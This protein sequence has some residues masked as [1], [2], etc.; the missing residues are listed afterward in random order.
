MAIRAL[1]AFDSTD[2]TSNFNDRF[3]DIFRVGIFAGGSVVTTTSYQV[4]VQPFVAVS[5]DG[6]VVRDDANAQLLTVPANKPNGVYICLFAQYRSFGPAQL[7]WKVVDSSCI[8]TEAGS[9]CFIIFALVTTS[10]VG[11][12]GITNYG[13]HRLDPIN[14]EPLHVFQLSTDLP[15]AATG[16]IVGETAFVVQ[17]R[18]FYYWTGTQWAPVDFNT[19]YFQLITN[20]NKWALEASLRAGQGTGVV[21]G[22]PTYELHRKQPSGIARDEFAAIDIVSASDLDE[23]LAGTGWALGALSDYNTEVACRTEKVAAPADSGATTHGST[24]AGTASAPPA[25]AAGTSPVEPV[26]I[27]LQDPA[28]IN[29]TSPVPVPPFPTPGATP[30]PPRLRVGGF[31]AIINGHF[32]KTHPTYINMSAAAA[33]QYLVVLEFFREPVTNIPVS[34]QTF[35]SRAETSHGF[36]DQKSMDLWINQ[37]NDAQVELSYSFAPIEIVDTNTNVRTRWQITL[38]PV[39]TTD[40]N[41]IPV[42]VDPAF[43]Q[44]S[45]DIIAPNNLYHYLTKEPLPVWGSGSKFYRTVNGYFD[46]NGTSPKAFRNE[47]IFFHENL[48]RGELDSSFDGVS[49]A[50]PLFWLNW[51]NN[52][53]TPD[54]DVER[55]QFMPDGTAG[56]IP[57]YPRT[58]QNVQQIEVDNRIQAHC[59]EIVANSAQRPS[60]FT[61]FAGMTFRGADPFAPQS[62][63]AY[64]QNSIIWARDRGWSA[65]PGQG[66]QSGA[67]GDLSTGRENIREMPTVQMDGFIFKLPFRQDPAIQEAGNREVVVIPL[68]TPPGSESSPAR[69]RRD[70]VMLTMRRTLFVNRGDMFY[71]TGIPWTYTEPF[72]YKPNNE[73]YVEFARRRITTSTLKYVFRVEVVNTEWQLNDVTDPTLGGNEVP[74]GSDGPGSVYDEFSAFYTYS[75]DTIITDGPGI[76]RARA[77]ISRE[78]EFGP[79]SDS[80]GSGTDAYIGEFNGR[81]NSV[82]YYRSTEFMQYVQ[83]IPGADNISLFA[84]PDLGNYGLDDPGLWIGVETDVLR[85]P[86][87]VTGSDIVGSVRRDHRMVVD[88][89]ARPFRVVY[90]IPMALVHRKNTN[91]WNLRTQDA[92]H[93]RNGTMYGWVPGQDL[94]ANTFQIRPDGLGIT[95]PNDTSTYTGATYVATQDILDL[96]HLVGLE[97]VE[98]STILDR[99]LDL[100]ARGKLATSFGYDINGQGTKDRTVLGTDILKSEVL[101]CAVTSDELAQIGGIDGFRFLF[102]DADELFVRP[103]HWRWQDLIYA[104]AGGNCQFTYE[105]PIGFNTILNSEFPINVTATTT[106][107]E[108]PYKT[109]TSNSRLRIM[110]NFLQGRHVERR[111][112][113]FSSLQIPV[114]RG[115]VLWL[116]DMTDTVAMNPPISR[117]IVAFDLRDPAFSYITKI[118]KDPNTIGLVLSG[119]DYPGLIETTDNYPGQSGGAASPSGGIIMPP[120]FNLR[121]AMFDR[122]QPSNQSASRTLED[123]TLP[124]VLRN[125]NLNDQSAHLAVPWGVQDLPGFGYHEWLDFLTYPFTNSTTQF[126]NCGVPEVVNWGTRLA[127]AKIEE[128]FTVY[129]SQTNLDPAIGRGLQYVPTRLWMGFDTVVQNSLTTAS[130]IYPDVEQVVIRSKYKS[131]TDS[132]PA[133]SGNGFAIPYLISG[134]GAVVSGVTNGHVSIERMVRRGLFDREDAD[135]SFLDPTVSGAVSPDPNSIFPIEVSD[136]T[137]EV[138]IESYYNDTVNS[139]LIVF[140]NT[141]SPVQSDNQEIGTFPTSP[142]F[143]APVRLPQN[144]GYGPFFGGFVDGDGGIVSQFSLNPNLMLSTLGDFFELLN[145]G[146]APP[147][148]HPNSSIDLGKSRV[149]DTFGHPVNGIFVETPE[150]TSYYAVTIAFKYCKMREG[151]RVWKSSKNVHGMFQWRTDYIINNQPS[152]NQ[153]RVPGLDITQAGSGAQRISNS[154]VDIRNS[155]PALPIWE[156]RITAGGGAP[157]PGGGTGATWSQDP[158]DPIKVYLDGQLSTRAGVGATRISEQW[159]V[160]LNDPALSVNLTD[161]TVAD[162]PYYAHVPYGPV[163]GF[164]AGAMFP[165]DYYGVPKAA[166]T[167]R[168]ERHDFGL[169]VLSPS[170][171]GPPEDLDQPAFP[172]WMCY[173][174]AAVADDGVIL[175][176]YVYKMNADGTR[177]FTQAYWDPGFSGTNFV[178]FNLRYT[179]HIY[180][181]GDGIPSAG[182]TNPVWATAATDAVTVHAVLSTPA[183]GWVGKKISIRAADFDDAANNSNLND[184]TYT[185]GSVTVVSSTTVFTING[186][187]TPSTD[188]NYSWSI[189]DFSDGLV[190]A[191]SPNAQQDGCV[192]AIHYLAMRPLGEGCVPCDSTHSET[193]I[194]NYSYSPYQGITTSADDLIRKLQGHVVEASDVYTTS[195][196]AG[197]GWLDRDQSDL[198]DSKQIAAFEA[199]WAPK[200][201]FDTSASY[202]NIVHY[203]P[204]PGRTAFGISEISSG[205]VFTYMPWQVREGVFGGSV[206]QKSF[207]PE[208]QLIA[209]RRRSHLGE[210]AKFNLQTLSHMGLGTLS[211]W[212]GFMRN[213][214][215]RGKQEGIPI[216]MNGVSAREVRHL[217]ELFE[218]DQLIGFPALPKGVSGMVFDHDVLAMLLKGG[219]VPTSLVTSNS[220]NDLTT[221]AQTIGNLPGMTTTDTLSMV[222]NIPVTEILPLI[223]NEGAFAI[224]RVTPQNSVIVGADPDS[225]PPAVQNQVVLARLS[226][227]TSSAGSPPHARRRIL[228]QGT[229]GAVTIDERSNTTFMM[230]NAQGIAYASRMLRMR[231][232][233]YNLRQ[234][235]LVHGYGMPSQDP[236][237]VNYQ[238]GD[239]GFGGAPSEIL[240]NLMAK[241]FPGDRGFYFRESFTSEATKRDGVC[242]ILYP[243]ANVFVGPDAD[244]WYRVGQSKGPSTLGQG[245]PTFG[246]SYGSSETDV[247]LPI[248]AYEPRHLWNYLGM[249]LQNPAGDLLMQVTS[250]Y[251]STPHFTPVGGIYDGF[252]PFGRP[253]IRNGLA[254]N[255]TRVPFQPNVDGPDGLAELWSSSAVCTS[256]SDVPPQAID[257]MD[258]TPVDL[259]ECASDLDVSTVAEECVPPD[260][261]SDLGPTV[262]SVHLVTHNTTIACTPPCIACSQAPTACANPNSLDLLLTFSAPVLSSTVFTPGNIVVTGP[263]E[264]TTAEVS[265][266]LSVVAA[267]LVRFTPT[268]G[269]HSGCAGC[270]DRGSVS[271]TGTYQVAIQNVEDNPCLVPMPAPQTFTF[272]VQDVCFDSPGPEIASAQLVLEGTNTP[273]G[274]CDTCGSGGDNNLDL[275]VIFDRAVD[276][277]TI[278]NLVVT[279]PVE[280]GGGTVAGTVTL[281]ASAV[282]RFSPT[283][284]CFPA[285]PGHATPN[286]TFNIN[287]AGIKDLAC[288]VASTSTSQVQLIDPCFGQVPVL[289][290]IHSPSLDFGPSPQWLIGG[291]FSGLQGLTPFTSPP[292][293]Y[294]QN[295]KVALQFDQAIIPGTLAITVT[296]DNGI[297]VIQPGTPTAGQNPGIQAGTTNIFSWVPSSAPLSAAPCGGG[298]GSACFVM[299][300]GNPSQRTV[301]YTV[302]ISGAQSVECGTV[303]TTQTFS[304]TITGAQG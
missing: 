26:T 39:K 223:G 153:R 104:N 156:S 73:V 211:A 23:A 2:L 242:N 250:G 100:L 284:H 239:V 272:L 67:G 51:D 159:V 191:D 226:T 97:S 300:T 227:D 281:G 203:L 96:R 20:F 10:N 93:N 253:L 128:Y 8:N 22:E 4:S 190:P 220:L 273:C 290:D 187:I 256:S 142:P 178:P 261:A 214:A 66:G 143:G 7:E 166:S 233:L 177:G 108:S 197:A 70:L 98:L 189:W 74:L 224:V 145:T 175:R 16:L 196:G 105:C 234:M 259:A 252:V 34:S 173:N 110:L 185:I 13:P 61:N 240:T 29:A 138:Q 33:G 58:T 18:S 192:Y 88:I 31:S 43:P 50:I 269:A 32:F 295:L 60:G 230:L 244:Y 195:R 278:S 251:S 17:T 270:F 71:D 92:L 149:T 134:E 122:S 124:F 87:G 116:R 38:V 85:T 210:N 267:N 298:P 76:P 241:V 237:H 144:A 59:E 64:A 218:T 161:M 193:L 91:S 229:H 75:G 266:T 268:A 41:V 46:I 291:T 188:A 276:P 180:N 1:L 89:P 112:G 30:V 36:V 186:I 113:Q 137:S 301:T 19:D 65:P 49:Y 294:G 151:Y 86:P 204:F 102:S 3:R 6:M 117:R 47:S 147:F 277:T 79:S 127:C 163:F 304:L 101:T 174:T 258:Q 264:D 165:H 155:L 42:D 222:T 11:I 198:Q 14:K 216:A 132:N 131:I 255:S 119:N 146:E 199:G 297:G 48:L 271:A 168:L 248:N 286:A 56:I 133:I 303:M 262:L 118:P 62:E 52:L 275:L 148:L 171:V 201:D 28:V 200:R 150:S 69:Q 162:P 206:F 152:A 111:P 27:T 285:N 296:A 217:L 141:G 90:A 63:T 82:R 184:G 154:Y 263:L 136:A 157:P 139:R 54:L 15:A 232:N 57:I 246:V 293:V 181:C 260:C 44:T 257:C 99:S 53:S 280:T 45:V 114:V 78:V 288:E 225:A 123:P 243:S 176:A 215:V 202:S 236:L 103:V 254:S 5:C 238:L 299:L 228:V 194:A 37:L 135:L 106:T 282:L 265:G 249:L 125:I 221:P 25:T 274:P 167:T 287:A 160:N 158:S 35:A 182:S 179:P 172:P 12:T 77:L 94:T 9:A 283:G 21:S 302:I 129:E 126:S 207:L 80:L 205:P 235:A 140:I 24:A 115:H 120:L 292:S 183:G 213:Q 208:E 72:P 170:I 279:G 81:K 84:Q 164:A 109:P 209:R 107:A 245:F 247:T 95:G 40:Y 219:G 83:A 55:Q 231:E 169:N 212:T 289:V 121:G 130:Y 68:G